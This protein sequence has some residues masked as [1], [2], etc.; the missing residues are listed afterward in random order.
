VGSVELNEVSGKIKK[1]RMDLV[2]ALGNERMGN[3]PRI[4]VKH[5]VV[6]SIPVTLGFH[7]M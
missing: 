5:V 3:V 1:R 2:I 6:V 7:M 4:P